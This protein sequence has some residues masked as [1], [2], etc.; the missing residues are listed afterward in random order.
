MQ[1]QLKRKWLVDRFVADETEVEF[2]CGARWGVIL[3]GGDGTRLQ[4]LT[5]RIT[6]EETPKQF[7][8]LLG[9]ETLLDQTRRRVALSISPERTVMVLTKS[10]ERFYANQLI[11]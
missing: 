8:A 5:R 1:Y 6:G 3:A 7:C 9:H 2:R 4:T 10:H 11:D